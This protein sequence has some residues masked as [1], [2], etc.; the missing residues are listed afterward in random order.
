M[1]QNAKKIIAELKGMSNPAKAQTLQRFFKTGPGEYGEGDLFLG[2]TN[3]QIRIIVKTFKKDIKLD[4]LDQLIKNPYHEIRLTGL[5]LL[6][7]LFKLNKNNQIQLKQI[8]NYYLTHSNFLNNWDLVD[9][10]AYKILGEYLRLSSATQINKTLLK[11][12]RSHQL[13]ERRIAIIST[14]SFIK[15]HNFDPTLN[16]TKILIQDPEDLMHKAVGWMLREVGKRDQTVLENFLKEHYCAM[17]RTMLR[18][19][20]ERLS[21]EKRQFYLSKN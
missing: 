12:A 4:D 1:T 13:W 16:L 3:P 19:A 11:L 2:L 17:P 20:I 14:F 8:I 10:T 18:Y 21:P 9:L 15:H 6:V 5:L 7:E